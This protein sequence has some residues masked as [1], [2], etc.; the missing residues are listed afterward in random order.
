MAA[1]IEPIGKASDERGADTLALVLGDQLW[2]GHPALADL[3]AERGQVLMIEARGEGNHVW[4]HK[5]RIA[6]FLSAMRHFCNELHRAGRRWRYLTLDDAP[7]LYGFSE[8]LQRV[9]AAS[10]ARRLVACECGD[11]R[12]RDQ[13]EAAARAAGVA[14]QWREDTHFLCSRERFAR[15]AKGRKELRMEFF[16]REMRREHG[17]LMDGAEPAGGR[18]N[19]DAENREGFPKTGPGEIPE[20]AWFEPD[21]IT[22]EVFDAVQRHF[23]DHPGS[24]EHFAWPVTREQA[25]QVLQR[26]IDTRLPSFGRYQDA[27]WTGTPWGWHALVATSLNLHLL[28]P[29]EVID[30]AERAWRERDLDLASVEGFIRQ[31]L[32]WREFI[33]GVY[34]HEM[35]GLKAANHYG[36]DRALPRWYWSGHTQMACM[37]E[38]VGQ[39]LQHGHAH[40]IQRLMVTGQFALLAEIQPQAVAD[41][42]LAA[43]VDAVEWVELPNVAGMALFANGGSFTSKPYVASGQYIKRMSNYCQ[44]CRYKPEQRAGDAACPVTTLYWHFLDKHEATLARHPRTV[45]MAKSVGRLAPAERESVRARAAYVLS[46]LDDL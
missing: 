40:H 28:T 16:Y 27:M 6:L 25:L 5:A 20:P 3:D 10:G 24:L 41:W 39:T 45:L 44:G 43:Y 46:H 1:H 23:A 14:L 26:F 38:V 32:G 13:I 11:L 12:L 21:R 19:F 29:R 31:V 30:A 36:H 18:W 8:R 35:P 9:L 37:R 17:V 34:F 33:R 2:M 22:R 7:D 4:S 15:W 42:Y